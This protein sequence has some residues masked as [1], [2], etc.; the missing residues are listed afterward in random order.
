[1]FKNRGKNIA[2]KNPFLGV[3]LGVWIWGSDGTAHGRRE[4][5]TAFGETRVKGVKSMYSAVSEEGRRA[6]K[7]DQDRW[8]VK[9]FQP[10]VNCGGV[11]GRGRGGGWG[12]VGGGG[13]G[14]HPN[15]V[16]L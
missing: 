4:A 2:Q 10:P 7:G 1:M 14:L 9:A 6:R 15:S 8:A 3:T 5:I 12:G 16:T 13:G 11:G